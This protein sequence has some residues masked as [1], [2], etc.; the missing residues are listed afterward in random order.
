LYGEVMNFLDYARLYDI[1]DEAL[2]DSLT[3]QYSSVD[4]EDHRW[5]HNDGRTHHTEEDNTKILFPENEIIFDIC[6]KVFTD[7]SRHFDIGLI[8]HT[9]ARLSKYTEGAYLR[10][11]HDHI[12]DMFDG[13]RRGIPICTVVGLLNDD[14]KGGEFFLCNEDMELQKGHVI[15]FPSI[16]MYPHEVKRVT[17]GTRY[18]FVSWAW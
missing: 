14:F 16:F 8:D 13:E 15:V 18:S 6:G 1:E 9:H 2:C 10:S 3:K 17:K 4:W 11:H 7:Y 5:G 12:K